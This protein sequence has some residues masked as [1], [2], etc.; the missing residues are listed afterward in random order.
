[1]RSEREE[2]EREALNKREMSA[3]VG[4]AESVALC[5]PKLSPKLSSPFRASPP[6]KLVLEKDALFSTIKF[7]PSLLISHCERAGNWSAEWRGRPFRVPPSSSSKFQA[8][9]RLFSSPAA[10]LVFPYLS[11]CLGSQTKSHLL[12]RT[13]RE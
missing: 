4:E 10:E 5:P 1:M 13:L 9:C 6:D 7:P 3:S 2:G 11:A 8:F 12:A